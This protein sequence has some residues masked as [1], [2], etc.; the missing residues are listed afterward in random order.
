M[1]AHSVMAEGVLPCGF[2]K[3]R[4]IR[5][6]RREDANGLVA[7]VYR[8]ISRDFLFLAPAMLHSPIPELLAGSWSIF[9]ETLLTGGVPRM[10]KEAIA[11]GV[12]EANSCLYGIEC[13]SL[14]LREAGATT[15]EI[16]IRSPRNRV[17][18]LIDWASRSPACTL[19][20]PA[21]APFGQREAPEI[22][23]TAV[24]VHYFN[25]VS[26]VF[27]EQSP[28]PFPSTLGWVRDIFERLAAKTVESRVINTQRL[29]GAS[30]S[31]LPP[32]DLPEDLQWAG[33]NGATAGAF[34][35]MAHVIE[36]VC[37]RCVP[38]EI[39]AFIGSRLA[40]WNGE[41]PP[42]ERSWATSAVQCLHEA[43][44]PLATLL[45]LTLFA[46]H[47]V[48]APVLD[49]VRRSAGTQTRADQVL[50]GAVSWA[51]FCA[52]R[53]ASSWLQVG[54]TSH[55]PCWSAS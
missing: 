4:Y 35:R 6:V 16:M 36:G 51:A 43:D 42:P 27:L 3:V 55:T 34:A 14:R 39:R 30:L 23:G 37:S 47:R 13:H 15:N 49:A 33:R 38:E 24:C 29:A 45:L 40:S 50:L 31:L 48:D 20:G 10:L 32:A 52:A 11:L 25:R 12:S 19:S 28:L 53:R 18:A 54:N 9:R 46:S 22:I 5:P 44:R 17:A 41:R 21:G 8:E 2:G 7:E 1:E 26:N